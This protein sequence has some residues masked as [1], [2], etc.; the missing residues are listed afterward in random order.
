MPQ[1]CGRVRRAPVVRLEIHV[2]SNRDRVGHQ[3][4]DLRFDQYVLSVLWGN[5]LKTS[6]IEAFKRRS[7][8]RGS[9]IDLIHTHRILWLA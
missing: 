4:F 5:A 8:Y 7:F 2:V 6:L 1:Q 9:N 3:A